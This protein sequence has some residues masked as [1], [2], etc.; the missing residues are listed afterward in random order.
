M[1]PRFISYLIITALLISTP[2]F[3]HHGKEATAI[4]VTTQ[5]TAE[6]GDEGSALR[7]RGSVLK[8]LWSKAKLP[9][10]VTANQEF[11]PPSEAF[12]LSV[13]PNSSDEVMASWAIAKGYYL[14]RDKFSFSVREPAGI[15]IGTVVLPPGE[16]KIDD[17]FGESEVYYDR[18][19]AVVPVLRSKGQP[20]QF[21]LNVRYQGCADAGL[22]YPPIEQTIAVDWDTLSASVLTIAGPRAFAAAVPPLPAA[23]LSRQDQIAKS[24]LTGNTAMVV[25]G[26][27]G[28]GLLLCLTP[29]V[30]PMLPILSGI[31]VGQGQ[32][33]TPRRAFVLSLVYVLAMAATYTAAGIMAGLLGA[34]LQAVFQNPVILA[35]FAAVFVAL[36]LSMFGF[37][38]LELPASWQTQFTHISGRLRGGTYIGVAAMGILSALIV[39]P[40]VAAPL[41]GALIYIGQTGDPYLGGVALFALSMGMGTPLLVLGTSGGR[42]LPKAGPWM[43]TIEWTFGFLLLVVAIYLLERIVPTWVTMLLAAVLMLTVTVKTGVLGLFKS[44]GPRPHQ[45][46]PTLVGASATVYALALLVG[47]ATGAT[48]VFQP[49]HKVWANLTGVESIEVH[50]KPVNG[51]DDLNK[52][53][54]AANRQ[55]RTVL[56]DYYADWCISCKRM[57][58]NT[59]SAQNV[60]SALAN[61]VLLQVDVT[62]HDAS[63]KAMLRR[64]GLFGPPAI[65]F[66]GLNGTERTRYRVIGYMDAE[67]FRLRVEQ[68]LASG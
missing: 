7:H 31:I 57:E 44:T 22:C 27:F 47:V 39:G 52:E 5:P 6:N 9:F 13:R 45:L 20:S 63:D 60:Q 55:G 15:A 56:L 38:R 58:R 17:Y 59:F 29:C 34:N 48:D 41:A 68:A 8:G 35:G 43:A 54:T 66:F 65:L 1:T 12:V 42:L 23:N 18:V 37:Y 40:C 46:V 24:L 32:G 16:I 62:E 11:L 50:F 51:L 4:G 36:A 61:T 26:F 14:Y 30:L 21:M 19:R 64:F 2:V 49:L 10:G 67:A 53:I 33:I 28:F 3:S 25:L